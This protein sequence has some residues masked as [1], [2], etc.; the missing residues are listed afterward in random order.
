MKAVD[1]YQQYF[2]AQCVYHNVRRRAVSVRLT[3]ESDKGRIRYTVGIS[4]FPY[5]DET[6]FAVSYDAAAERELYENKGRRSKKR[7]SALLEQ[8]RV[9][10]NALA[11]ELGGIIFWDEPLREAQIG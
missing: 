10:A 7:E 11:G 6:D 8:L 2:S 4:F 5:A 1:V 3:A 9:H